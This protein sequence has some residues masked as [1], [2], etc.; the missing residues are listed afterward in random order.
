MHM[1]KVKL[2]PPINFP[3]GSEVYVVAQVG[4]CLE[5]RPVQ[6]KWL[7]GGYRRQS[8]DDWR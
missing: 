7:A 6:G 8:G 5:R 1:V 3:N 2:V 4:I